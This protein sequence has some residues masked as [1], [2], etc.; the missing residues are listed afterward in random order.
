MSTRKHHP[1]PKLTYEQKLT[2]RQQ[3]IEDLRKLHGTGVVTFG[4]CAECLIP[5]TYPGVELPDVKTLKWTEAGGELELQRLRFCLDCAD[6]GVAHYRN[7]VQAGLTV[8]GV[9]ALNRPP[10]EV[11]GLDKVPGS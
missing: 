3:V 5:L 2:R 11:T 9:F 1:K 6:S 10:E 4:D 8:G 7:A